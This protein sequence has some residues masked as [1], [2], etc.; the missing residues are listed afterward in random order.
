MQQKWSI[1]IS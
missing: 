1:K